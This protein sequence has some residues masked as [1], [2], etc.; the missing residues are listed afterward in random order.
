MASRSALSNEFRNTAIFDTAKN[1][2]RC[3]DERYQWCD[4]Q[5]L[6]RKTIKLFFRSD[7][8][9]CP[10]DS[11]KPKSCFSLF[12]CLAVWCLV[13]CFLRSTAS[14]VVRCWKTHKK[15]TFLG[16]VSS[17]NGPKINTSKSS[18]FTP[19]GHCWRSTSPWT[20]LR[21]KER[22]HDTIPLCN[23]RTIFSID[24]HVHPATQT[25]SIR[26]RRILCIDQCTI[27]YG[28]QSLMS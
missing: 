16:V 11:S 25:F 21:E 2:E 20:R 7:G 26:T 27:C 1:F 14:R 12:L 4:Y 18:S 9:T 28:I 19:L 13:F 22:K 15:D 10:N 3:L 23:S 8:I 24:C 6:C 17:P 5:F